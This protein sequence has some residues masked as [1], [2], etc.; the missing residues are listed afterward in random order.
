[1][2]SSKEAIGSHPLL[3]ALFENYVVSEIRKQSF[4]IPTPPRMYHFRTYSGTECDLILERDGKI[5]PIEIKAK[6]RPKHK[7]IKGIEAFRKTH[8]HLNIQKGLVIAPTDE[9]YAITEKD[10]VIPY[11]IL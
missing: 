4:L 2:I 3:G 7:D 8:P 10:F 6:T 5:F 1:M 11:D 9:M